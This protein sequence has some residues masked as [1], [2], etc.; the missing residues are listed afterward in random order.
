MVEPANDFLMSSLAAP[1][2][3]PINKEIAPIT[4]T[5][6]WAISLALKIEALRTIK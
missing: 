6:V 4:T 2:I 1:I 5:A 3:A